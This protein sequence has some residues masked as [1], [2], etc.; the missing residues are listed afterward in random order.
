MTKTTKIKPGA[1]VR[2]VARRGVNPKHQRLVGLEGVLVGYSTWHG[3]ARVK[4][5]G[6]P[7][8]VALAVD[9]IEEK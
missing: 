3:F 9:S 1:A 7:R 6:A 8:T 2:V 4:L 5:D